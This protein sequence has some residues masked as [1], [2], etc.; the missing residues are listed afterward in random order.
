[1]ICDDI[2]PPGDDVLRPGFVTSSGDLYCWRCGRS[3]QA[4]IDRQEEQEAEEWGWMDE[5]PY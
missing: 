5:D 2:E 1:M 4:E 3:N